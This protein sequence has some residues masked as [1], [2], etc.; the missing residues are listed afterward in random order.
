LLSPLR[1]AFTRMNPG[2]NERG[3]ASYPITGGQGWSG[4]G[5]AVN[6]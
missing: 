2:V 5:L 4:S 6:H 1:V 3:G